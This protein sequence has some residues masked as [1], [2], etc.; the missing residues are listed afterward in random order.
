MKLAFI[1]GI[2]GQDGSYLCEL[3]LEKK[4]KI[5]GIVRRT[6]LL[7]SHTRLDHIR[8]KIEL[9]YGDMTDNS[10]LC[11][12]LF[13]IISQNSDFE[14][15][16]IYNLAAQS[17]VK[18]SFEIPEYTANVDGTGVMRLL[19]IIR[20]LPIKIQR[21]IK[22]YQ[23]GTSEMYGKVLE[24]PQN[25]NTP[26]NPVSPYAAAKLYAYYMVKCYR[27]GYNLFAVNGILF[28]HE[29]PRRGENFLTMKVVNAVKDIATEKKTLIELG[30]L[31]SKRDWGHA[32]D[33][34]KGMWMMLQQD[35]PDDFVLATG[36][37]YTVREFVNRA[38][39][40]KGYIISWSGLGL[41][42]IGIDQNN[43]IRVK[44]NP[45]YYRPCEV[46]LLLGDPAKAK[47]ELNWSLEFDTLDKLIKDMFEN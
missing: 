45:K 22:F 21:K 34:V 37:T 31:D 43:K 6:S 8:E 13:N 16:E 1:T 5:F 29:S 46:D 26:F 41:N 39:A 7:Y 36:K 40:Y 12:Y 35:K 33:Y 11:N 44:I 30:N 20:S 18:V 14:V 10:G 3:L 25:E 42:E 32:K 19:E 17:H 47:E 24:T 27:E 2:T 15:L 28:N 4:Y 38:F 23:A 9:R